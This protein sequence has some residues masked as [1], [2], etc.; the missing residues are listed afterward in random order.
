[1][2]KNTAKNKAFVERAQAK[3]TGD[4][5]PI[6][7]ED[8]YRTSLGK[9]LNYYN[10]TLENK[11]RAKVVYAYLKKNNRQY[12]DIISKAPDY[13]LLTI[14]SLI[15]IKEKGGFLTKAHEDRLTEKLNDVYNRYKNVQQEDDVDT[16]PKAPVIS[17]EQRVIDAAR[18]QSEEIDY[19]IDAFVKNKKTDFSTKN[20]LLSN[21][22]SG[23]VAK[24]IGEYYKTTYDEINEAM[25]G[26]DEQL[27]EGYS[28]LSKA[29]LKRFR[30]F[31]K[32]IIDDCAQH[33]VVV[34][35]PRVSKPKAPGVI[36]K[37][38]KYMIKFEELN[39]K[40]CNPAEIVGADELWVYNTKNR[41]IT[42]YTALDQSGLSVKGTTITNYDLSKSDTMTLRNPEQFFKDA[43]IGK[44]GLNNAI[45]AIKTKPSKP[46]GRINAEMI[47][48]G[49]F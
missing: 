44:R 49:A 10:S 22:I 41:R 17:I 48:I 38:L 37:R 14:S 36:V 2:A 21:N 15:L 30:D 20:H 42:Y 16:K 39:L 34:K 27:V 28:H 13:E 4:G 23:M 31:I 11:E 46:N 12:Y 40:S 47:L 8:N 45:K 3:L 19:A 25:E 6:V 29:E 26:N 1:M 35:K 43:V 33:Q 18:T 24:K 7:T 9:A 32:S 5:A